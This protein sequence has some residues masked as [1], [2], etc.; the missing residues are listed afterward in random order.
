MEYLKIYLK[1]GLLWLDFIS[2]R[3]QNLVTVYNLS[4][5]VTFTV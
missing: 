1:V 3:E 2:G 5:F 4:K